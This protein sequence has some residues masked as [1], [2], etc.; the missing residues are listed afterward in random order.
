MSDANV[1]L[2]EQMKDMFHACV[3]HSKQC[4]RLFGIPVLR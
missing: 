1:Y 4:S 3:L 2:E